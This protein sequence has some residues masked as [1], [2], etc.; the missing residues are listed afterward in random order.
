MPAN[1]TIRVYGILIQNNQVLIA[2]EII[3][4]NIITKFPGGGLEFGEGMIDC[5]IREFKEELNIDINV[6]SHFYTTDFFVQSAFNKAVQVISIYYLV[7]TN[8][9]MELPVTS[10]VTPAYEIK[11]KLAFRWHPLNEM[12][13][14]NLSLIIDKKVAGMI[15]ER[16]KSI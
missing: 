13:E 12:S 15:S 3:K 7:S 9:N 10:K 6:D 14:E 1:F 2:D 4:G 8:Q 11:N 5:L 16:I